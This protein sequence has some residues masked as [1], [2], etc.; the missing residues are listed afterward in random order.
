MLISDSKINKNLDEVIQNNSS[1]LSLNDSNKCT[2]RILRSQNKH[3][4]DVD[5]LN[6]KISF[7]SGLLSKPKVINKKLTVAVAKKQLNKSNTLSVINNKSS[8]EVNIDLVTDTI[9]DPEHLFEDNDNDGRIEDARKLSSQNV[10]TIN[11]VKY[12]PN[13]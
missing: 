5:Y 9:I 10:I 3:I 4:T 7:S 12:L 8:D 2:T 13:L 1:N 6:S 11:K